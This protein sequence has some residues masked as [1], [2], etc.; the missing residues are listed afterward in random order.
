MKIPLNRQSFYIYVI[1]VKTHAYRHRPIGAGL[2]EPSAAG[3]S[4]LF[5]LEGDVHFP[6]G[7]KVQRI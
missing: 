2:I 4:P 3:T 1:A 7:V 5:A 6:A